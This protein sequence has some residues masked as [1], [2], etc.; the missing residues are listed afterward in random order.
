MDADVPS[1][2]VTK[3][4]LF[5][6]EIDRHILLSG[7]GISQCNAFQCNLSSYPKRRFFSGFPKR[8]LLRPKKN[9]A[10]SLKLKLAQ[11]AS[12]IFFYCVVV[13]YLPA[14]RWIMFTAAAHASFRQPALTERF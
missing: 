13:F 5:L 12:K 6:F 2:P 8:S 3:G 14:S 1:R 10:T 9:I 4:S 7:S 11:E